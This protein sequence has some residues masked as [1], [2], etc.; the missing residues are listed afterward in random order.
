MR[1]VAASRSSTGRRI[2]RLRRTVSSKLT[3]NATARA[4][5]TFRLSACTP[6][7]SE[8]SAATVTPVITFIS[9]S[10]A[11]SFTRSGIERRPIFTGVSNAALMS[12]RIGRIAISSAK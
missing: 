1:S 10:D 8:V 4:T 3:A 6:P 11:S 9:G 12:K 5:T 7:P 2:E